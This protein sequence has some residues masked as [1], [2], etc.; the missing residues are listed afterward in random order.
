MYNLNEEILF[1]ILILVY[2]TNIKN[3]DINK[4]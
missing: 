4:R 1:F 2:K 3:N